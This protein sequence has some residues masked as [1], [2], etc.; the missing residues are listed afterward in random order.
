[1]ELRGI[2]VSLGQFHLSVDVVFS[3]GIT[4]LFGASGAGKTTLLEIIAG[5]R[6]PSKGQ[7]TLNGDVLFDAQRKISLPARKRNIGYVPQDLAL[8]PHLTVREN[9][10]YGEKTRGPF[11]SQDSQDS[12]AS[13][14]VICQVLEIKKNLSQYPGSLS[15]GEKQ[16]VAFAR[17]LMARPSFLLLDE[18]LSGLDQELKEKI[19]PFILRIRDEFA[20]PM[21]YVTHA[22]AEVMALCQEVI[23]LDKGKITGKGKPADYFL[24]TD[25]P[26]YRLRLNPGFS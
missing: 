6:R 25:L 3:N 5:L 12:Q 14:D 11:V 26:V 18:P 16:R 23:F 13:F 8:F 24:K 4:G 19:I 7:L 2:E 20:L 21:M 22:S 9:I 10:C 15:G 1:M 17:A